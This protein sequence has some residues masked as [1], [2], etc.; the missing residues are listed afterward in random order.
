M[1]VA[2]ERTMRP[3]THRGEED[4]TRRGPSLR[5]TMAVL[6]LACAMLATAC[7]S[8]DDTPN[9]GTTVATT[10]TTVATTGTDKPDG[11]SA[12]AG[13]EKAAP[14]LDVDPSAPRARCEPGAP[15]ARPLAERTSLQVGVSSTSAEFFSA[16]ALGL[17]KGEFEAENLDLKIQV[18]P[19]ADSLQLLAEGRLDMVLGSTSAALFNAID[20]GFDIIWAIGLGHNNPDS[21]AGFWARGSGVE[22]ADLRGRSVGSAVGVGSSANLALVQDM[23]SDMSITDL[24][25]ETMGVTDVATALQNGAVDA[26]VLL[27]PFWLPFKDDPDYTFLAPIIPPGGNV[28]GVL[29]GPSL[30][31]RRDATLVFT[32]AYIRT[33]NTYLDGDYKADEQV[34]ADLSKALNVP[35]DRLAQTPSFI[36][37]WDI[38]ARDDRRTTGALRRGRRGHLQEARA[39]GAGRRP[40]LR[41]RGGRGPTHLGWFRRFVVRDLPLGSPVKG[42]RTACAIGGI[43]DEQRRAT[44]QGAR[45]MTAASIRELGGVSTPEDLRRDVSVDGTVILATTAR[46]DDVAQVER[47]AAEEEWPLAQVDHVEAAT[48]AANIQKISLVIAADDDPAFVLDIVKAIRRTTTAPVISLGLTDSRA[49]VRT[50]L[51]GAD[52]ALPRGMAI[53]ELRAQLFALLRRSAETWEPAVRYLTAGHLLVDLWSRT[54]RGHR[55]T[56]RPDAARV[57]A[58]RLSDAPSVPE[59]VLGEDRAEGVEELGLRIGAQHTAHPRLAPPPQTRSRSGG[60]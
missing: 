14:N 30:Q 1:A 41:R 44:V 10:G 29:F 18:V 27:D 49:R 37:D 38:R 21:G 34:L 9:A 28:A 59:S 53:D 7:S 43:I 36:W 4:V 47:L 46:S 3:K 8:D 42:E 52:A 26:A 16:V 35:E 6:L 48:W 23:P 32:R 17:Q 31:K 54:S 50:L 13:C 15:A 5:Q 55:R 33:V 19:P 20:Q 51:E 40:V 57:R 2:H 22:V 24:Q 58:A 56:G 25:F 11:G 60:P 45:A 12:V 39:R